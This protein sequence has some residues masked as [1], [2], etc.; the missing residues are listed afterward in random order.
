VTA[1]L[2]FEWARFGEPVDDW[3]FLIRFSG[4]HMETVL[5]VIARETATSSE[6]LRSGCEIRE[7]THLT[8]DLC[9]ALERSRVREQIAVERLH[10]LEELITEHYWWRNAS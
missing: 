2:D 7:A 6:S 1:L 9:I 3:F 8:S 5:D 4:A 10:S